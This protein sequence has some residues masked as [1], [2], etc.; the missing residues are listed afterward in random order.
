MPRKVALVENYRVSAL[1]GER[2]FGIGCNCY[3]RP[4]FV[5]A[6]RRR[7]SAPGQFPFDNNRASSL[8]GKR[9]LNEAYDRHPKKHAKIHRYVIGANIGE[10]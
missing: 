2:V 9:Q 10:L 5:G 7:D 6:K 1:V 3:G 4:A 8:A